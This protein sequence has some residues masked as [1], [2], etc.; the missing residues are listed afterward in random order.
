VMQR[1]CQGFTASFRSLS[2]DQKHT[3]EYIGLVKRKVSTNVCVSFADDVHD[4]IPDLS[5]Y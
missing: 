1:R 4:A 5:C 2:L 3:G